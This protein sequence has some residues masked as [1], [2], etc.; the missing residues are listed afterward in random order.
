MDTVYEYKH[1]FSGFG[2]VADWIMCKQFV[3]DYS[4]DVRIRI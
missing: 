4:R 3:R 2:F 1:K